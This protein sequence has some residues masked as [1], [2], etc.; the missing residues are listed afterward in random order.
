MAWIITFKDGKTIIVKDKEL[1]VNVSDY[2]ITNTKYDID[3]VVAINK[4][5]KA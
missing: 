3:D 2:I 5:Y 1:I 4:I